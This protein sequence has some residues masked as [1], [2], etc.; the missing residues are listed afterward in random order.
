VNARYYLN[1]ITDENN[2]TFKSR[3]TYHLYKAISCL[4][5]EVEALK[6]SLREPTLDKEVERRR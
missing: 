4:T 6:K 5:K 2:D 1:K 3:E